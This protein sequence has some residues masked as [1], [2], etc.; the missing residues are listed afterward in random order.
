MS[1]GAAALERL[2]ARTT[3][4]KQNGLCGKCGGARVDGSVH[5][6]ACL[7]KERRK[8]NERIDIALECKNCGTMQ[9][10]P[11]L[12][13]AIMSE[14]VARVKCLFCGTKTMKRSK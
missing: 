4:W 11:L 10:E 12:A 3:A 7:E 8:R 2:K 5:C 13:S 1:G 14:A 9:I 6:Q